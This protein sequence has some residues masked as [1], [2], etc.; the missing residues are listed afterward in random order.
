MVLGGFSGQFLPA[1][2]GLGRHVECLLW[3][4]VAASFLALL[5]KPKWRRGLIA[6][7]LAIDAGLRVGGGGYARSSV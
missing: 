3:D 7:V 1:C 2:R 6:G 4:A 5:A